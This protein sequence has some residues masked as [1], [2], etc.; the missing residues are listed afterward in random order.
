MGRRLDMSGDPRKYIVISILLAAVLVLS[1]C[2]NAGS[3]RYSVYG[4]ITEKDTGIPLAGAEVGMGPAA[5]RTDAEGRCPGRHVPFDV[6]LGSGA[7]GIERGGNMPRVLVV[8]D[9][10]MLLKMAEQ[11]LKSEYTVMLAKSGWEAVACVANGPRPDI[12]VIFL[13]GL[14]QTEHELKGL[15]SGAV[16]YITKPFVKEILL[17]RLKVHLTVSRKIKN[18]DPVKVETL[19]TKL[20]DTELAV[21]KL[22]A[23]GYTNAEIAEQLHYSSNY[24]K[25]VG[26]IIF[27]KL[28]IS[29]RN[30]IREFLM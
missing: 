12:P 1:G 23:Q 19:R 28:G 11:L 15:T 27:N 6:H 18:L 4:W 29:R 9:D 16:D 21:A 5:A 13:T 20:N 24:V 14:T 10:V 26:S 17:A 2:T 25:K 3:L 7:G 30:E 22:M 8:D